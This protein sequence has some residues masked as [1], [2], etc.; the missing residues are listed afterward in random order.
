M[1]SFD[2]V[3]EVDGHEVR[4]AVDQTNKE[5]GS[6]FDFKGSD[7]RVEQAELLLNVYAD[8]EFKLEQV[9]DILRTKL[10]K[11]RIDVRCLEK[12]QVEKISGNKVKQEI[13]VK[14]GLET[15][16]AKKIIKILKENKLKVQ[17]SIQGDSVRVSGPKR[18]V[19]Q[20]AIQI[21][22]KTITDFPLQY[23]NFRD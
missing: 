2:I 20:E 16:L 19:L 17:A 23:Q 9:Q 11:R 10:T 13:M 7:A 3:S 12:G 6:R 14:T 5:V 8:D 21:V 15:E 22:Q 1:P 4:N 18:D